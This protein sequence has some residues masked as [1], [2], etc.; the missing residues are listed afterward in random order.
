[1]KYAQSGMEPR[2]TRRQQT[3]WDTQDEAWEDAK[4]RIKSI[5]QRIL[6]HL[7]NHPSTCDEVEVALGMTHQTASAAIHH[8]MRD[9]EIIAVEKRPTRSGRNARVWQ[10]KR[11]STLF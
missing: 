10:V 4:H 8:L 5:G 9:G 2:Q 6:D 7:A 3:R 11:P 1:M